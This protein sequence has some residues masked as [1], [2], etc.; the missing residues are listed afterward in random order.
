MSLT[1]NAI[2][3][4]AKA[5]LVPLG[6]LLTLLIVRVV[7]YVWYVLL[8]RRPLP[9]IVQDMNFDSNSA[10]PARTAEPP[11]GQDTHAWEDLP[12]F[13]RNYISADPPLSRQLA[14][15]VTGTT[16]PIIATATPN[17]SQFDW[18]A[19]LLNL[20][21]PQKQ[22]A[23]NIYVTPHN[24]RVNQLQA[25][26]QIVKTP[27]QWIK[28]SK[29]FTGHTINDLASAI[30]GFCMECVQLQ[31]EFLRRTARWEHW[32]SRG[33]YEIFRRAISYQDDGEF[34]AAYG[35]YEKASALAPGNIRLGEY[36][37]SLYEIEGKYKEATQLYDALHCLWKKN[38]E[39]LYRSS[40]TRVNRAQELLGQQAVIRSSDEP[41]MDTRSIQIEEGLCL[42]EQAQCI[43]MQTRKD[44]QFLHVLRMWLQTWLPRRRDIGERKYWA[45]W[46]GR[47]NFRQPL[48]LLRRSKRY[49]YVS[50]VRVTILAN[51][52]LKFLLDEK[53][54]NQFS[55]DRSV[56]SVIRLI[57][58]KRIGW[59]AH[60]AAACYFSRA[61]EAAVWAVPTDWAKYTASFS[62]FG[63]PASPETGSPKNWQEC[64]ET[65]AVGEIG[66]VL[67]N[68]CNQLNPQLLRTDPD[69]KRLH[70]A[71]KGADVR[72][73]IGP[74]ENMSLPA[75]KAVEPSSQEQILKM[76]SRRCDP[77]SRM[78][79]FS[80]NG[81]DMHR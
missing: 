46:L 78:T 76:P 73:L 39:I 33:S 31:P 71:F 38:I 69:M 75:T 36:R 30:G 29:I 54:D 42:I 50:A 63:S 56:S 55:I 11:P 15:G 26:V 45:S 51:E 74:I 6:L 48:M 59:L 22:A 44:L 67:R 57:R 17:G 13:L 62:K 37:A 3:A 35:A 43:L 80:P 40:A 7:S 1:H 52:I 14:P 49:E 58:R 70:D 9:I 20:V 66:R 68:P 18:T 60:W 24:S 61:A 16:S 28:A 64:C 25:S 23:Y 65:M 10:S 77:G 79:H 47:D 19:R 27:E 8:N 41:T 81:I 34:R 21:L 2:D 32:G 4:L 72:V 5:V 53:V 12:A